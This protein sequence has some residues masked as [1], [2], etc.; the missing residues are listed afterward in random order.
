[1]TQPPQH[2]SEPLAAVH[3]YRIPGHHALLPGHEITALFRTIAARWEG[4]AETGCSWRDE[5]GELVP[6]DPTS[7][8]ALASAIRSH[9]DAIDCRLIAGM[10]TAEAG[11]QS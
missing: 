3:V 2:P 11:D 8:R 9:A 5:Q 6:L 7:L 10:P 4:Y 1:M